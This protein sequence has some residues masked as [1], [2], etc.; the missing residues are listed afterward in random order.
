ERPLRSRNS[1][2]LAVLK[3]S[4][5]ARHRRPQTSRLKA[6]CSS[7]EWKNSP[8]WCSACS[9][10]Y[11]KHV[12]RV[13][14]PRLPRRGHHSQRIQL[15]QCEPL[16]NVTISEQNRLTLIESGCRLSCRSFWS[17]Y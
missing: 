2:C 10:S 9:K 8:R 12:P 11:R 3:T 4:S 13:T 5:M 17:R 6:S 1:V 16:R 14:P 7:D 15:L